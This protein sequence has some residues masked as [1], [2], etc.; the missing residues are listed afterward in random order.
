MQ[1]LLYSLGTWMYFGLI[2]LASLWNNKASKMIVGRKK[3]LANLPKKQT[4]RVWLH[5]ASVG[6]YEQGLPL[7]KLFKE[8]GF[9]VI[10]SIFSASAS[11]IKP[12]TWVD[13]ITFL[14]FDTAKNAS[15]F[16]NKLE[17]D[18]AI[19]VKYELWYYY[20]STLKAKGIP[21]YMASMYI[22]NGALI[23]KWYGGFFKKILAQF[24]HIFV[25]DIASK[26]TLQKLGLNQITVA[27]DTRF[28]QVINN[29]N[30]PFA[31]RV[32][33]EFCSKYTTVIVAGSTWPADDDL[34][35]GSINSHKNLGFIIAPHE[36]KYAKMLANKLGA[37]AAL[38]SEYASKQNDIQV[39]IID[40]I[41]ILKYLYRYGK[42]AYIGG[43]FGK[44]IHNILEPLAY[45][46]PVLIGPNHSRF[47]E[48]TIAK[49]NGFVYEIKDQQTLNSQLNK[50]LQNIENQY[51]YSNLIKPYIEANCNAPSIIVSRILQA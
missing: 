14:P 12:N 20:I 11:H 13:Y 16:I 6:E 21:C 26:T 39:L 18:L 49:Q 4:K 1:L 38:Y 31:D 17:P 5:C 47:L 24:S 30:T 25:Q 33:E 44:G 50:I 43:G 10:I 51:N 46:L 3:I 22:K 19:F 23:T 9:E 27:G 45:K 35:I 48:A 40:T 34:L 15:N 36:L 37:K 42:I 2:K 28:A 7:A 41:G 8:Q 29:A 32:V